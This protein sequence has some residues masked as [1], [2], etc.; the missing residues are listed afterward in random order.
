MK[1][2]LRRLLELTKGN[3]NGL[4][5]LLLLSALGSAAAILS[6]YITGKAVTLISGGDAVSWVLLCLIALYGCDWLVKFLQQY[7][8]ASVGQRII[9]AIRK[10]LFDKIKN[11]PLVFFDRRQHGEL[12]SRLTNDVDNISTTI[13]NSLTLLLTYSFTIVGILI[14]ARKRSTSPVVIWLLVRSGI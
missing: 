14:M 12:M 7:L 11:L 5:L 6:P 4:W 13:S 8:M 1:G 10:T 2:T 9:C 3:R